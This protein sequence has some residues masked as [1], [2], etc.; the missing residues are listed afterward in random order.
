M[1]RVLVV[2][3]EPQIRRALAINLHARG[4]QVDLAATG[5]EALQAAAEQPA[6]WWS[7]TLACPASAAWR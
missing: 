6:T 4:Y 7:W 2:D 5:E 3:D 1:S